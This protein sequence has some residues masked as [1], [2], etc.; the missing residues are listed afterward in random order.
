MGVFFDDLFQVADGDFDVLGVVVIRLW[1]R[2]LCPWAVRVEAGDA[3]RSAA[4]PDDP[5]EDDPDGS[6]IERRLD[7]AALDR[8]GGPTFKQIYFIS[9]S[10][11]VVGRIELPL[12][13]L[14]PQPFS[15]LCHRRS[16]F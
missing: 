15:S 6:G 2:I 9:V 16:G 13:P 14:G 1:S 12:P 3:G 8:A 4:V 10:V 7:L 11:H 5:P